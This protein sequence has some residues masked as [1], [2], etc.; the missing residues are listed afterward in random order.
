MP[1]NLTPTED[2]FPVEKRRLRWNRFLK[3]TGIILGGLIAL[4][5]L[6]TAVFL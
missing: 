3:W 1:E 6:S 5:I 2:A 4:L